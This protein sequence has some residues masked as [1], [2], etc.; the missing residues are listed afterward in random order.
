M[1]VRGAVVQAFNIHWCLGQ[2]ILGICR[3]DYALTDSVCESSIAGLPLLLLL[4]G[5]ASQQTLP[6]LNR[7]SRQTY[8]LSGVLLLLLQLLLLAAATARVCWLLSLRSC[9]DAHLHRVTAQGSSV[10]SDR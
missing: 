10:G 4:A 9:A 6:L 5:F 2:H 7:P 8:C 1:C 3:W